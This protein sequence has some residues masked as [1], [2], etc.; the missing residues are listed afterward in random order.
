MSQ[1][2]IIV[3]NILE[4]YQWE[5]PWENG[6]IS[7]NLNNVH[8][9]TINVNYSYLLDYLRNQDIGFR[10]FFEGGLSKY[11]IY[12]NGVLIFGGFLSEVT[13]DKRENAQNIQIVLK[14]WLAYF[15][16][17]LYSG[18]FTAIDAGEIGWQMVD[19]VNDIGV[20]KGTVTATKTRDRTYDKDDVLKNLTLLSSLNIDEGFDFEISPLKVY[21]A[22]PR[23]GSD[24]NN[25]IFQEPDILRYQLKVGVLGTIVNKGYILGGGMGEG[26]KVRTYD[27]GSPYSDNFYVQEAKTQLSNVEDT[28]ILD[29]TVKNFVEL[30]K[31]PVRVLKVT[32]S[33]KFEGSYNYGDGVVIKIPDL[34]VDGIY[35]I[36]KKVKYFEK[37]DIDLEFL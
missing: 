13:F 34:S 11:F 28:T 16:Q 20:T 29:D 1:Y 8:V 32:V 36:K 35:R 10:D 5:L 12:E 21:T 24:R 19:A 27:V 30:R 37:P 17:R 26:Q 6:N 33:N 2:K 31:E 25:I 14:S 4:T 3:K 9:A 7:Y 15:A 23:L 22:V 18:V